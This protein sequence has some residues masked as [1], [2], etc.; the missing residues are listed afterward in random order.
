MKVLL[1]IDE[2]WNDQMHPNNVLSNWFTGMDVELAA[3]CCNPGIPK[4]HCC[5]QYFQITD[6]MMVKSIFGRRAG[7]AFSITEEQMYGK[8]ESTSAEKVPERF[9]AFMKSITNNMVYVIRDCIWLLGR[10]DLKALK[11]FV[12]DFSPDIVYCPRMFT[13]KMCRLENKVR[14]YTE[15]PF[16][17]F[18]ADDEVSLKQYNWSPIYWVRR[19]LNL[20]RFKKHVKLYKH[21]Y[22]FSK[23]Q[24]NEYKMKYGV[25]SSTLYKCG[26][27]SNEENHK[28]IGQPI[29][30][31]YA[32]SLYCKRWKTLIALGKALNNINKAELR[33]VLDVYTRTKLSKKA[34]KEFE[35]CHH[36]NMKGAVQPESLI[37]I[38]RNADIALHVESFEKKYKYITKWSFSTKI[39]DLLASSC[40]I[41]AICWEQHTGYKYLKENDA[42]FCISDYSKIDNM[43]EQIVNNPN[44]IKKYAHKAWICGVKNHLKVNIQNQIYTDFQTIIAS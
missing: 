25:P 2:M 15:A 7:R 6:A 13:P 34:L 22:T 42:A 40:A 18:V 39:I 24:C 44:M 26:D 14:K 4:N 36:V 35:K 16:V 12:M 28:K 20:K 27:F 17:A 29:R 31:I 9:Y 19:L 11:K 33:M 43:L 23:D 41:M 10:F 1:I 38:Y 3:I 8:G 30:L 37:D 32:G 21:Y 5:Y